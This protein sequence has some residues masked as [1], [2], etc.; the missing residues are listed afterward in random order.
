MHQVLLLLAV[1]QPD[2]DRCD[3]LALGEVD[4][5]VGVSISVVDITR[6]KQAEQALV[7]SEDHYRNAV[8]LSPQVPWTADPNGM[9]LDTSKRWESLTGL[10]KEESL[11]TQVIEGLQAEGTRTKLTIPAGAQGNDRPLVARRRN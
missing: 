10:T 11:G 4:E 5:V 1:E 9:I 7:E 3:G 8:E 6:R 2:L